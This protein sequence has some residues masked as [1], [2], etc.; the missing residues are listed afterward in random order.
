MARAQ[1]RRPLALE[2]TMFLGAA[3]AKDEPAAAAENPADPNIQW[4]L[5][6]M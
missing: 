2:I 3:A 1:A 6:N 5:V 4:R